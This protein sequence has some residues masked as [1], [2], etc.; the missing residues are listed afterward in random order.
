MDRQVGN[1][2]FFTTLIVLISVS[3]SAVAATVGFKP[4]VTY[5][6][7]TAPRAVAVGDF[8]DDHWQDLAV[9]NSGNVSDD[10]SV[11][12]LLG[13]G[14]GT[15]EDARNFVA[16]KNP[17]SIAVGDFNG[18]GHL[19][20]V[21]A[22]HGSSTVSMLLGN[23][24]GTFQT[25]VDYATGT[26][27][28]SVA[29]GDLD[30]NR[31]LD[32]VVTAHPA[33]IVSVLLG[34]GDGTLQPRVDYNIGAGNPLGDRNA[35]VIADLNGDGKPD[36]LA[37]HAA[38]LTVLLGN[39]DGTFQSPVGKFVAYDTSP[40]FVADLNQDGKADVLAGFHRIGPP[41]DFG[42]IS[43]SGNGDGS[44]QPPVDVATGLAIA[45]ADF[46]GDLKLDSV[47]IESGALSLSL[48][49]GN[50][51]FQTPLNSSEGSNPIFCSTTH[52]DGDKSPD[53]ITVNSDNTVS[54]LLNTTG[55]DFSISASAPTPGTV[56]RGQSST[57]TVTLAHL[58]SFDKPVAL[59]CSVQPAQSATCSL[60]PNS[61]SF[62]LNG[63]A[64]TTLTINTDS[65]T[66]LLGRLNRDLGSL[67]FLWPVAGFALV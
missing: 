41:G 56:S 18:D 61:I 40:A 51:T 1:R 35:V 52:L 36:L 16:G 67:Q 50:G 58:N 32:L 21:V 13:K 25:H 66:A 39:G 7:G 2:S 62:D 3:C 42:V 17:F 29:V 4:S 59:S 43:L 9:V 57:S 22:N 8:N 65:A 14:D 54:V 60:N 34:N 15:F 27:A 55:A 44:F 11:T 46:N 20:L 49:S 30:G 48:G 24:D 37:S 45:V 6:V 10:G 5:P 23:G 12:I 33:N 28:D 26:G 64:S 53:L 38:G 63:N 19:D 31:S 47:A